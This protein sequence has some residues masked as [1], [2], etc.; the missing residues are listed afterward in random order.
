M[1]GQPDAIDSQAGATRQRFT[2][3]LCSIAFRSEPIEPVV[4]RAADIGFD[5]VEV[6]AGQIMDKSDDELRSLRRLADEQG[7]ALD[8]IAPYFALTR[9][10]QEY[11]ESIRT[12]R[13]C[14]DEDPHVHRCQRDRR[15]QCRGD[16]RPLAA[17]RARAARDDRHGRQPCLRA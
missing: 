3:A 5:A 9:G 14:V 7:V 13:R 16:G 2:I 4:A 6:F 10:E 8:V 11:D 12:A 17:L 1:T 15:R